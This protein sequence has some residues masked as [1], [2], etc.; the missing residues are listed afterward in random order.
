VV[1]GLADDEVLGL[2]RD[3][4]R[5]GRL[6]DALR[7]AAAAEIADRSRP[8]LDTG[9]LSTRKG[10]RSATELLERVTL[11]SSTTIGKR[12]RLGDKL[13]ARRTL[14]GFDL[15][16]FFPGVA[17]AVAA[18][19]LGLD[20]A[21]AIIA[22][23]SAALPRVDAESL[24]AAEAELVKVGTGADTLTPVPATADELRIQAQVWRAYLDPDGVRPDE[25]K[26]MLSRFLRFGRERDG[27][28][29]V[30]GAILPEIAAKVSLSSF[31][32]KWGWPGHRYWLIRSG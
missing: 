4:E 18:G 29:P 16:P 5:V 19:E 14:A 24:A 11:V 26:A 23:L 22:G 30:T 27:L 31:L 1:R 6:A 10:C 13:R 2:A 17:A 21:E 25:D 3:A 28:V 8:D 32:C 9:R 12:I 15:D 7:V 20:S